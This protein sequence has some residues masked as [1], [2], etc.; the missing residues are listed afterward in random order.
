[1]PTLAVRILSVLA[2]RVQL[3][4]KVRASITDVP[5]DRLLSL[6]ERLGYLVAVESLRDEFHDLALRGRQ[7]A[8]HV[9][10]PFLVF[11]RDQLAI[12]SA[13]LAGDMP[14]LDEAAGYPGGPRVLSLMK[15]WTVALRA[16]ARDGSARTSSR[17]ELRKNSSNPAGGAGGQIS[18]IGEATAC[19]PA[20][21]FGS[22]TRPPSDR[23]QRDGSP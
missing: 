14:L 1:L 5:A 9:R 23:C 20:V 4:G 16:Y 3:A 12:L 10:D 15:L 17:N 6:P 18:G 2:D 7:A 21:W 13:F 8:E 11:P 22:T 19:V